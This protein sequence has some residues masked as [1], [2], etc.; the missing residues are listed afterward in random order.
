MPSFLEN[1]DRGTLILQVQV[2]GHGALPV[3]EIRQ[4]LA[5]KYLQEEYPTPRGIP[6]RPL[7]PYPY[8]SYTV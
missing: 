8:H 4:F 2:L 1:I 6:P 3:K 7:P 5:A